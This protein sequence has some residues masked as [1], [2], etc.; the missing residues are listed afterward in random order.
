MLQTSITTDNLYQRFADNRN[1]SKEQET[2]ST[3]NETLIDLSNQD[4]NEWSECSDS[5]GG[6][7]IQNRTLIL[8]NGTRIVHTRHCNLKQ[9]VNDTEP[10]CEPFKLKNGKCLLS[11][12]DKPKLNCSHIQE[13]ET[14]SWE[15]IKEEEFLS[16]RILSD[17]KLDDNDTISNTVNEVDIDLNNTRNIDDDQIEGSGE[18]DD[19]I[20]GIR[21][22]KRIHHVVCFTYDT[23]KAGKKMR[24]DEK[25]YNR[26]GYKR[27]QPCH[28][29]HSPAAF[30][31]AQN[32]EKPRETQKRLMLFMNTIILTIIIFTNTEI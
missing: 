28:R 7:G 32:N 31:K 19:K 12:N 15:S 3:A 25:G 16:D 2:I 21:N 10:C 29:Q 17:L 6:C 14:V 4:W 18:L 27:R 30:S 9:C 11:R 23:F 20:V 8:T 26:K 22:K 24:D 1:K 5:C 13:N